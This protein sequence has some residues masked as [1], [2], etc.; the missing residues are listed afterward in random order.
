MGAQ[1]NGSSTP[2]TKNKQEDADHGRLLF[3]DDPDAVDAVLAQQL[4][5]VVCTETQT[6]QGSGERGNVDKLNK[7]RG[8]IGEQS[9]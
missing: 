6:R 4:D 2:Q 5:H 8:R 7:Q 9:M 3:V 1:P